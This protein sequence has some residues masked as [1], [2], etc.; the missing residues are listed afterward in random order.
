M[1]ENEINQNPAMENETKGK[2]APK[3]NF[4]PKT[5]P[6]EKSRIG[7]AVAVLSG[8]GGVG[9]SFTSCYIA[10]EL[11]RKGYKVGILDADI[12]GP[13]VPFAFGVKGPVYG[14]GSYFEPIKSKTG[15]QIM[16]S[17]LL[18]DHP[19]D[20]IVW[21]GAMI[22]T[23]IEQFYTEVI[24]DVDYLIID[25]AP[26]TGDIALTIFQKIRL[27]SAV[28]V[29]SPQSL[30]TQIVEK[31]AKMAE[32][33]SVTLLSLVENMSYVKCPKCGER[34]DFYGK[35]NDAI[36]KDHGIPVFDEIPFDQDIAKHMDM[37][38][39]EN[40]H[41]PYLDSTVEAIIKNSTPEDTL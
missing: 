16:S 23:L 17:N 11:A 26:G 29:A 41:V 4:I 24:W 7:H 21:R 39:I 3:A 10:T 18:L 13:S 19:D 31:S 33:L 32:M 8:K 12:T 22:S 35:V 15:I 9:K 37:G 6:N 38:D 27:S 5:H 2:A 40:L 25:M 28:L 1:N 20:P 30:V 14:D 36:G 34:I